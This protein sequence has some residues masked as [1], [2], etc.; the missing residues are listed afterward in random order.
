[1]DESTSVTVAG[2]RRQSG[3]Q[4]QRQRLASY[5]AGPQTFLTEQ[6]RNRF[7]P[8]VVRTQTRGSNQRDEYERGTQMLV[9]GR[10][11]SRDAR[12]DVHMDPE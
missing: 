12:G 3:A 6:P 7:R 4:E 5:L 2:G 1:M 9:R 11:V 8:D 10:P